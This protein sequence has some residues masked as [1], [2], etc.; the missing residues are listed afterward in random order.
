MRQ[1]YCIILLVILCFSCKQQNQVENPEEEPTT[2]EIPNILPVKEVILKDFKYEDIAKYAMASI[3]GQPPS[4]IKVNKNED[5]YIVSYI[6]KS[7]SQKFSYKIK[8]EGNQI[9]WANIDGRWRTHELDEKIS[10]S[11]EDSKI[12]IIQTFNDGSESI[13]EFKKGQ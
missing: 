6:R 12:K 13:E 3:M 7:D 5:K 11:E 4:I 9:I 1:I 2:T 8:F 10:F